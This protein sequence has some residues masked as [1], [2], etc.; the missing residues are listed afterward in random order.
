MNE[1]GI[2]ER[3]GQ[4]RSSWKRKR[5]KIVVHVLES[6]RAGCAGEGAQVITCT[7]SSKVCHFPAVANTLLI[8]GPASPIINGKHAAAEEYVRSIR[9]FSNKAARLGEALSAL[10]NSVS[11]RPL[12]LLCSGLS[13]LLLFG[14]PFPNTA[15]ICLE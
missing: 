13:R 15:Q 3:A 1:A 2:K 12:P 8:M 7:C 4:E 14:D 11:L 5:L 9:Q 10:R 6:R